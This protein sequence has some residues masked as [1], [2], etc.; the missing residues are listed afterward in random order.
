MWTGRGWGGFRQFCYKGYGSFGNKACV[1]QNLF[2][3]AFFFTIF[4]FRPIQSILQVLFIGSSNPKIILIKPKSAV[5]I[6][7]HFNNLMFN[8]EPA[9]ELGPWGK[10]AIWFWDL[11]SQQLWLFL[12][13]VSGFSESWCCLYMHTCVCNSFELISV[14]LKATL[15]GR[16][17]ENV[18][19]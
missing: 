17:W 14:C 7:F 18:T 5:N 2:W 4:I 19:V 9:R 11:S 16:I 3:E 10:A 12:P 13:E 6:F 1:A 15:R 8:I